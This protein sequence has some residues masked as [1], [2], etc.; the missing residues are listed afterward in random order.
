MDRPRI[1]EIAEKKKETPLVTTLR[2]PDRTKA[3]PG[4]YYM[5]WVPGMDEIPMSL[6]HIG[7]MKGIAVHAKGEATR[8]LVNLEPGERIG[9]R[10][11][12][13]RGF[14][15]RK[16]RAL[17][18][19]GGTGIASLSPL[20]E[21]LAKRGVRPAVV[22]GARTASELLFVERN[23]KFADVTVTTDDGTEGKK[24]FATDATYELLNTGKYR[25]VYCCGPEL[26]MKKVVALAGCPAIP[27]Q[28]SMERYMK[29]GIGICDSCA[30]GG[31]HICV[32]GPVIDGSVAMK[33]PE[34][35]VFR[36]DACGRKEKL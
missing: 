24:G 21:V 9:I 5:I 35:G 32:E 29:C 36:R 10:G 2:F 1:V 23:R 25:Q 28:L 11:P 22:I 34:F 27:V 15:P 33:L 13:G 20:I 26:M 14:Q 17:V 6:C 16:G 30:M 4:Q 18:V 31:F 3:A 19:A 8:A 7:D 12:Y